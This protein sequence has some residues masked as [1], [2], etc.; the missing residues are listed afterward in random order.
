MSLACV[1]DAFDYA[2]STRNPA[3]VASSKS[4]R[5]SAEVQALVTGLLQTSGK[6]RK[7]GGVKGTG[8]YIDKDRQF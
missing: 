1:F 6:A 5:K 2:K 3:L 8:A 4:I 7:L